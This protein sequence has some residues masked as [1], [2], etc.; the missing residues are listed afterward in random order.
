MSTNDINQFEFAEISRKTLMFSAIESLLFVSGEPLSTKYIARIIECDLEYTEEL[1]HAMM[2]RY[3]DNLRGIKLIK[4]NDMYQLVSKPQNSEFIQKLLGKNNRQS[5]SQASLE[6][7][8]IIAYKQPI[9]RI[10]ID[11]IRGVK[12]DSAIQRL[13]ERNL[14]KEVGRLEVPGRPIQFGTTE[15]FL[16]QFGLGDLNEMPSIELF[17]EGEEETE[18]SQNEE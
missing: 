3:S 9:T 11:E 5:L 13:V 16:R 2:V 18:E 14:V 15:E 6:S 7:L 4:V 8:A 17:S 10:D 12:S 1:L